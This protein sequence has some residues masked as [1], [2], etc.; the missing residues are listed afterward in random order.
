MTWHSNLKEEDK[1]TVSEHV[2]PCKKAEAAGESTLQRNFA[3][4]KR[5]QTIII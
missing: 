4:E 5:E 2:S 3:F 1:R